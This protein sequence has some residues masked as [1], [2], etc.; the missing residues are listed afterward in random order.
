[1][2]FRDILVTADI[3][4]A[5]RWIRKNHTDD[6]R[7]EKAQIAMYRGF[8]ERL[9]KIAPENPTD[10]IL[11][12]YFCMDSVISENPE[13]VLSVSVFHRNEIL[14]YAKTVRVLS[15]VKDIDSLSSI[16]IGRLIRTPDSDRIRG[17]GFDFSEWKEILGWEID[18]ENVRECGEDAFVGYILDEMSFNGIYEEDQEER[19]N[20]LFSRAD[21][22]DEIL[23]L[24]EEERKKR[25]IPAENVFDRI[26][27]EEYRDTRT[28]EEKDA[29]HRA[30]RKEMVWNM[31]SVAQTVE[32][33][34]LQRQET[35]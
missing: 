3:P 11:L 32:K 25:L 23:A 30:F 4:S 33:Y 22:L 14:P 24:P 19:R 7:S 18:P 1:M 17:Y 12:G 13:P 31:R 15:A 29:E 34:I 16:G 27:P 2:I 20:E 9:L 21:E 10:E 35:G 6:N 5:V 26:L 8:V 28:Q